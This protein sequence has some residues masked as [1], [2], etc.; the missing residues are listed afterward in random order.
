MGAISDLNFVFLNGVEWSFSKAKLG[1]KK[2]DLL[3]CNCE[4][5]CCADLKSQNQ[6]SFVKTDNIIDLKN[7]LYYNNTFNLI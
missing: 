4:N 2:T 7:S 1:G 5:I 6:D 3:S